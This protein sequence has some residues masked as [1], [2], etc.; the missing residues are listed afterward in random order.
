[1]SVVT[2]EMMTAWYAA[3]NHA[4]QALGIGYTDGALRHALAAVAPLIAKAER[5]R[6]ARVLD[7]WKWCPAL[8]DYRA[9][10]RAY[11]AA[12]RALGDE[13]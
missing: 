10:R 2:D 3:Y 4:A 5:E 13:G 1:M 12:I 7:N 6:C 11:A 8:N 9:C